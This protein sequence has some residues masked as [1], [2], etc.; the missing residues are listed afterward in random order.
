MDLFNV[1]LAVAVI[2][3]VIIVASS[4]TKPLKALGRFILNAAVGAAAIFVAN[5]LLASFDIYIGYNLLTLGF[6]GIL[7]LPGFF[8]LLVI[9]VLI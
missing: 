6:T 9:A 3:G 4:F 1:F 2:C 7:G 5:K 8:S